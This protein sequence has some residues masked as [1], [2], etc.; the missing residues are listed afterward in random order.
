M[1]HSGKV[2]S[3]TESGNREHIISLDELYT[4]VQSSA[5][6][7]STAEAQLRQKKYGLNVL[8]EKEKISIIVKFGK[9]LVNFFALLLWTGSLLAF[10]AEHLAPGEGNLYIGIALIGVVILNALFTF[11]QEYQS[12]KIMESFKKMMPVKIDVLRDGHRQEFL[13]HELVPGDVIFVEEGDKIPA[14]ARLIVENAL[15]VDHSSLTGE[16]E[17]QLRCVDCT[18]ENILESRNMIF[19]GTL[20]NSGN[21]SA[22]VY[23]T[24]MKT[25]LGKIAQLTKETATVISPLRKELN[26]FISVISAIAITLGLTF[27][28]VSLLS[29]N[30]LMASMIFAI[31]IIVANVPEGLLPTV[32]LCLS[33]ASRR[34]AG[35]MALIKNLESVETLGSTTVICTDKT[36]TITE[37]KIA[38][39]T[40]VLNLNER[41]VYEKGIE[42]MSGIDVAFKIAVLCNNAWLDSADISQGDPTEGALLRFSKD[43]V[44]TER[45]RHDNERLQE[46]PFDSKVK[47]MITVNRT[48]NTAFSYVKGAPEAVMKK[49]NRILIHNQVLFIEEHHK[50]EIGKYYERL[51]SRGERVLALAYKNDQHISDDDFLFVALVG[52]I[53]PPRKEIPE[54]ISKCRTAGIRVIMITGDY[55]ITAEAVA[56]IA[57][58]ID[59]SK[60]NVM[61]GEELDKI[62]DNQLKDFLKKDNLI[63]ARSSPINKLRIVTT[64]QSM[65]EVVTVTGDG[66]NDAPA[67]KNADMGVAMGVIGTEVAKESSDMV[68]LDDNFA[69]IVNAIE[70]GRTVYSNIKKFIAYILTSNVPEILPFIAFV[71]L[72][73]PLP[74]T[75]VLILS[76]DLGTDLLPALGLGV[77]TSEMDVMQKKPRPRNERLLSFNLLFMSYGIIGML[78]AAAG[79]FAYFVVLF[80]GGWTWGETLSATD[81]LYLKAV[82][83]F[84]ASIVICQIADVLICRTRKQ[85]VLEKGVFS[86]KFIVWGIF[87]ELVLLMI[88]VYNPLTHR[89]FGTHSLSF[90]E[91]TLSVPFALFIFF[92]DE[93][94]KVFIRRNN[95]VIEKYF[96]CS[97]NQR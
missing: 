29:G 78:Q 88:I 2:L 22:L 54:A 31:G 75:V 19:S 49:C 50:S 46:Y 33:M 1:T 38:V 24:G 57:G 35:K 82:T 55:G 5:Q 26:H 20:V 10:F 83:A 13:A 40:L 95:L 25:Q 73:I 91:L 63:F 90:F 12:E 32:T 56:R 62:D 4:L 51:A 61:T 3:G 93:I 23:N 96:S 64:L 76:I 8:A 80:R 52:M 87:S 59:H 92:G 27:F 42:Q 72:G 67:L 36:G 44:D 11:I 30:R 53:D 81:P 37:N 9:H 58:M 17:P 43:Y 6:G 28:L 77:E 68:L 16:S 15:R 65:G 48:G 7:L 97:I 14:D 69:T 66:V 34:M 39:N 70:E 85:S 45:L 71:L 74:L 41:D 21:G 79:F 94:R 86:N 47:R 60:P 18:H 84:F 89:I